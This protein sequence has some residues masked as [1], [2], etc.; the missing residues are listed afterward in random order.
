MD[1][2]GNLAKARAFRERRASRAHSTV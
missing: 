2:C 1:Q